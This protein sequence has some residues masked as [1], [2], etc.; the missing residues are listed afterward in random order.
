MLPK[1][2]GKPKPFEGK[3]SE[4]SKRII[5]VFYDVHTNLDMVLAKRCTRKHM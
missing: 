5:K 1:Y 2:A 4:L 3:H